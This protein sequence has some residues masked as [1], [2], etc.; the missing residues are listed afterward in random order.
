MPVSETNNVDTANRN[1]VELKGVSKTFYA[2]AGMAIPALDQI[3]LSVRQG[4][5]LVLIGPTGC[6]KTTLLNIMAGLEPADTQLID[7]G[8]PLDPGDPTSDWGLENR[9][10]A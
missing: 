8:P 4:E 7:N 9:G 1:A 5:F 3:E 2:D 6:G 10:I